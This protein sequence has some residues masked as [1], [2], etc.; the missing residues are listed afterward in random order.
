MDFHK[1]KIS[2]YM[3]DRLITSWKEFAAEVNGTFHSEKDNNRFNNYE[4]YS[5]KGMHGVYT[6][7]LSTYFQGIPEQ[8]K[9]LPIRYTRVKVEFQPIVD[10]KLKVRMKDWMSRLAAVFAGGSIKVKHTRFSGMFM[11]SGKPEGVARKVFSEEV[12][13]GFVRFGKVKAEVMTGACVV[14][15]SEVLREK[16][17]LRGLRELGVRLVEGVN[18]L[19]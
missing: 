2:G 3:E 19:G 10:V 18:R 17:E 6:V 8:G 9:A 4:A 1:Q 15:V 14:E 7:T 16:E 13:E 5:V 12:C 11:V